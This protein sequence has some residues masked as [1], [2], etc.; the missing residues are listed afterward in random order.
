MVKKKSRGGD[1][2]C[3]S[4]RK[5]TCQIM[6]MRDGDSLSTITEV[7]GELQLSQGRKSLDNKMR[8]LHIAVGSNWHFCQLDT[9]S[10]ATLRK[11]S[12]RWL[13]LVKI[14]IR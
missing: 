14:V 4:I 5:G 9:V 11:S 12:M 7:T 3:K 10:S 8:N 2:F 13:S 6:S 1:N